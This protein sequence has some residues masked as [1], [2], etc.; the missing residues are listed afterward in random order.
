MTHQG[1][2]AGSTNSITWLSRGLAQRGHDVF[3]A[4]R[5]ESLIAKRFEHGPVHLVPLRL[6]KGLDLVRQ[7]PAWKQ[8][9]LE[10]EIDVT[11]AHASLDRHLVSYLRLAGCPSA[12]VQ[13]RRNMARSSG[14]RVRGWFDTMTTDA[15]VAVSGEVRNDLI[16][17]GVRP[18]H[19]RVI[20]NGL[21]LSELPPPRA[22]RLPELRRELGLREGVP[23]VGV[24][25]RRKS[26]EDLLRAAALLPL[27]VEIVCVGAEEDE[28]LRPL[29]AA[30]APRVGVFFL[31]FRDDVAD[32]SGLFDLFVLPSTIEGFS[33][34]LLEAMSHSIACIATDAG[35]NREALFPDAGLLVPPGDA[36]AL[37][38]AMT[39]LL[40]D[41]SLRR[42]MGEK[43]RRR[44]VESYDV[45]R[46]VEKTEELYRELV[47]R[48][49]R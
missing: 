18:D 26:H 30:L 28:S 41:G 4:C 20:H 44:I 6:G 12:L 22:E 42:T 5:P 33:L 46:T 16:R 32:L 24:V 47:E 45:S 21:P 11:N 1:D 8:W 35:G 25:A 37:A 2:V 19:V 39:R 29:A 31:G 34:A 7:V 48:K 10:Q 23:I 38:L 13:T 9:I 40:E 3:L 17:K 14:G 43:A 36:T 15:I 49:R 27:P